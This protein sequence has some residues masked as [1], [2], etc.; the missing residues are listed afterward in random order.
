M[1]V[2]TFKKLIRKVQISTFFRK[3]N[4]VF[5]TELIFY[6]TKLNTLLYDSE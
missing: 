5:Y 3:M 1:V 4:Y 6:K 2:P